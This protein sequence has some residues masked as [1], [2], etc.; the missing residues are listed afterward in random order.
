M[1]NF[2]NQKFNQ[3]RYCLN[4]RDGLKIEILCLLL[5]VSLILFE[6]FPIK[7]I[8]QNPQYTDITSLWLLIFG[9]AILHLVILGI[10]V[11]IA[12]LESDK[13][14]PRLRRKI[15]QAE[16]NLTEE[17]KKALKDGTYEKKQST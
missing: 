13:D 11:S 12:E 4:F 8:E 3:V 7:A 16:E 14:R 1:R 15:P 17:Q 6:Y 9:I 10:I 5:L 2:N